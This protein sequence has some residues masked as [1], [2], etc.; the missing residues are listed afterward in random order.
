MLTGSLRSKLLLS[1]VLISSLI[2]ATTLMLVRR[3]VEMRAREEIARGLNNSLATFRSLQEQREATLERSAAL[4]AALPPL[5]AVMTSQDKVTIQDASATFWKTLGSQLFVLT[6]RSGKIMGLHSTNAAFSEAEA[7]ALISRSTAGGELRGWWFGSGRIFEVFLQPIY[8]GS[9]EQN[10]SIGLLVAGYEIDREVAADI[11]RVASGEVAF[12]FRNQLAATTLSESGRKALAGSAGGLSGAPGT[13]AEVT[14]GDDRYLAASIRLSAYGS[15]PVTLTV[16]RSFAETTAFLSS[17][18][19]WIVAIWFAAVMAE[20]L[21]AYFVS[22]TFTRPLA[23][24]AGGVHALELGDFGYP[25]QPRGGDE[26]SSLTVAFQRM[27]QRIEETQSQ[28]IESERLA[29]IGRMASTISHDLRHPLTA[30]LAYAE[31]LSEGPLTEEQRKD[32]FDE[33]RIA[34]SRMTDEINSLLG[35][36][37]DRDMV[38]PAHGHIEDVIERAI[39]TVKVLPEFESIQFTYSHTGS[40]VAWFDPGKTERVILNLLFNAC[41]A[42][43]G[44]SGEVSITS[45]TSESGLDIRVADNGPGIPD[46]ILGIL[47]QPFVSSGKEKGIGLGLTVVQKVMRDHGGK[48]SVESTGPAGTVFSLVFPAGAELQKLSTA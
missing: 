38:R 11:G 37:K 8:F 42:F 26:V 4:M 40:G 19:R 47:F 25:L 43:S 2:T 27:R 1:M 35:F 12:R 17:L 39:Q 14:I 15:D 21:L 22:T 16:F 29:T 34:V 20:V 24:L 44:D 28:L 10:T 46:E 45:T 48:V 9:P 13:T 6:D 31:F 5:K 32:F 30:I 3:R 23:E 18:N 33:I 41:E 7:Q 36:S